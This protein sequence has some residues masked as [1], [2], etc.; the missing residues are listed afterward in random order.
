MSTPLTNLK[1]AKSAPPGRSLAEEMR[2]LAEFQR[3]LSP[4]HVPQP[5]GWRIAAHCRVGPC[6]GGNYYDCWPLPG[7]GLGLLVADA[8]GHGGPAVLMATQ[9]RLALHSCP[10]SSGRG[11]LPFCPVDARATPPPQAVLGHLNRI[12]QDNPLEGEFVTAFYGLL[13]PETGLL[14]YANAGHPAPRLWRAGT[15]RVEPVPDVSGP[16]L[17]PGRADVDCQCH[18]TI[19]PG[20]VLV[21]FSQGLI[22]APNAAGQPLGP[23]R[24]DAAIRAGAIQGAEE[25][26]RRVLT[27][28]D[29]FVAGE[30]L[31]DDLTLVVVERT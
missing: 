13:N 14:Q 9:V 16:P 25:V 22:E 6:P 20:D 27:A 7:G 11:Q 3:R 24:L 8:S 23:S 10:L 29:R 15:G 5:A 28:L 19:E 31:Q 17:G 21:C 2:V 18:L 1:P 12:L 26:Q 30:G 4:R